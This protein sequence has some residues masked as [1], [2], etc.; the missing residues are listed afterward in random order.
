MRKQLIK[1]FFVVCLVFFIAFPAFSH[2]DLKVVF[3]SLSSGRVT[4]GSSA[5]V[6][7][8]VWNIGDSSATGGYRT[9]LYWSKDMN[10]DSGDVI[11]ADTLKTDDTPAMDHACFPMWVSIPSEYPSGV[12]FILVQVDTDNRIDESDENNNIVYSAYIFSSSWHPDL[13]VENIVLS[14]SSGGPNYSVEVAFDVRNAGIETAGY[15]WTELYWSRDSI[16]DNGDCQLGI[17][18]NTNGTAPAE[19]THFSTRVSTPSELYPTGLYYILVQADTHNE[20][21]ESD[22]NNNTGSA[23]YSYSSSI[24]PD[25]HVENIL[26]S[27][28]SGSGGSS[29]MVTFDVRNLGNATAR[30]YRT[31]LYW[32]ADTKVDSGDVLLADTL[33]TDDTPPSN[34]ARFPMR[35]NIP[36]GF[37]E[38]PYYIFIQVDTYHQ[39]AESDE[40]NNTGYVQFDYRKFAPIFSDFEDDTLNDWNLFYGSAIVTAENSHGGN[41]SLKLG[42]ESGTDSVEVRLSFPGIAEPFVIE[43]WQWINGYYN[44]IGLYCGTTELF[45]LSFEGDNI[46]KYCSRGGVMCDFPIDHAVNQ[47]EWHKIKLNCHPVQGKISFWFDELY[48]CEVTVEPVEFVDSFRADCGRISGSANFI[49]FDD[50]SIVEAENDPVENRS[51]Y[52]SVPVKYHLYNNYPNPFNPETS[53][54]YH[55]P[56]SSHIILDI[57]NLTGEKIVTLK[58]IAEGAGDYTLKWNGRNNNKEVVPGGIY[59]C[60]IHAGSFQKTIRMLYLK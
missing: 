21:D 39:V 28:D 10:V 30:G 38:G 13:T 11:L 25:L 27:S 60:C 35:V 29:V 12:Y 19:R 1:L 24:H 9:K 8:E 34:F 14:S 57:Y 58:D 40:K 56:V 50:F 6:S 54:R 22:E 46:P 41:R 59:F 7:F 42:N 48:M 37:S 4:G 17:L 5:K 51:N 3:T 18:L 32:S 44:G 15:Y 23:S 47:M 31:K 52:S 45:R 20:V 53:I 16:A 55:L 26:L 33:K 36:P 43:Y 49:Y 2:P